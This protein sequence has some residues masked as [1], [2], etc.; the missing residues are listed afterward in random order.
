[1]EHFSNEFTMMFYLIDVANSDKS[2]TRVRSEDINVFVLL[3][4]WVYPEELECKVQMDR[5][6]MT[7]LDHIDCSS[8]ASMPSE[9][10]T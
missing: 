8:M 9:I 2:M 5:W 1:M 10:A 3:V 6:D 7:T 4:C